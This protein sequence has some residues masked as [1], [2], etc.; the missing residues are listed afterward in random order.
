MLKRRRFSVLSLLIGL[1]LIGY[2]GV[3]LAQQLKCEEVVK[4]AL[5]QIKD[6]CANIPRNTICYANGSASLE[7][8]SAATKTAFQIPGDMAALTSMKRI[9]LSPYDE[10]LGMW[11]LVM[12]RVQANF[13]DSQPGQFVTMMLM[14]DVQLDQAAR[15]SNNGKPGVQ[16]FIF[17]SGTATL[18]CKQLPPSGILLESPKGKQHARLTVNGA[19]LEIGSTEI[20]FA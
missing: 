8:V 6:K 7:T 5:Q 10:K 14:G 2:N 15:T 19:E 20:D 3:A 9:S 16:G 4:R 17:K 18:A 1:L 13:P 12:L 11:G